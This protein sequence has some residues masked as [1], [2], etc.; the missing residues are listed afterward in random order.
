MNTSKFFNRFIA[1]CF[2]V[3]LFSGSLFAQRRERFERRG[4]GH[5]YHYGYPLVSLGLGI[6]S[7]GYYPYS[8]YYGHGY[9]PVSPYIGLRFRALPFGFSTIYVGANPF[10][11]YDGI[12]YRQYGN[13]EYEVAAPPLGAKVPELPKNARVTVINGEKYYVYEGTYY[14]E[15]INDKNEIWYMVVGTNGQINTGDTSLE[16]NQQSNQDGN[17]LESLP[18]DSKPV[19][20]N[21]QKYF[22]APSGVY[23]QEV[24]DGSKVYYKVVGSSSQMK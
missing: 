13:S 6:A 3:L 4:Y 10:Y 16:N 24:Q 17:K 2:A 15:D 1:I 12:Y 19:I 5:F 22:L 11:Y 18:A 9:Y 8:S 21:K 20:I 14:K 23:Y 7:Y